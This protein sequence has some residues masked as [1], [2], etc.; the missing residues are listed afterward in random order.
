MKY[1][2]GISNGQKDTLLNFCVKSSQS[3][4]LI[5]L[6]IMVATLVLAPGISSAQADSTPEPG[7]PEYYLILAKNVL[8]TSISF[9]LKTPYCSTAEKAFD[10]DFL[11]G[12]LDRIDALRSEFSGKGPDLQMARK[13]TRDAH[14]ELKRKL[15]KAK[16]Q[17]VKDCNGNGSSSSSGSADPL[18]TG[19]NTTKPV[20]IPKPKITDAFGPDAPEKFC[21]ESE[22][23]DYIKLVESAIK[24]AKENVDKAR[25]YEDSLEGLKNGLE[26]QRRKNEAID[27]T[28]RHRKIAEK[29]EQTLKTI[30]EM[31]IEDCTESEKTQ[32]LVN[33]RLR[34]P[35]Q[36]SGTGLPLDFGTD[37]TESDGEPYYRVNPGGINR[38]G[39]MTKVP[40]PSDPSILDGEKP[41]DSGDTRSTYPGT[42]YGYPNDK[43]R[44][45][46][47]YRDYSQPDDG[48]E[49]EDTGVKPQRPSEQ[50]GGENIGAAPD[51]S[52]TPGTG[53][54]RYYSP[55]T[56]SGRQQDRAGSNA[57]F[58]SENT[59]ET[60][61]RVRPGDAELFQ[62]L[63]LYQDLPVPFII[64]DV[65]SGPVCSAAEKQA[66]IDAASKAVTLANHNVSE[67]GT[68][69]LSV[70]DAL[71]QDTSAERGGSDDDD[72]S[73]KC[74]EYRY[75]GDGDCEHS[76]NCEEEGYCGNCGGCQDDYTDPYEEL[77]YPEDP[78]PYDDDGYLPDETYDALDRRGERIQ[79]QL[80]HARQLQEQAKD[81][82]ERAK[83]LEVV[84]CDANGN[85]IALSGGQ[86]MGD[87][88]GTKKG[89][90]RTPG[91][92]TDKGTK[93]GRGDRNSGSRGATTP[94]YKPYS[95]VSLPEYYCSNDERDAAI[96]R[97]KQA[98][99]A[100]KQ[101]A[102]TA[103]ERYDYLVYGAGAE[104]SGAD[105]A[106]QA[107]KADIRKWESA[108]YEAKANVR[109]ADNIEVIE[110]DPNGKPL[111]KSGIPGLQPHGGYSDQYSDELDDARVEEQEYAP[112]E[113]ETSPTENT[114]PG[115]SS[116]RTGYTISAG[117]TIYNSDG[118]PVTAGSETDSEKKKKEVE[119]S[120][121]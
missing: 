93:M 69:M 103:N 112:I 58:D 8:T 12:Q 78:G 82:L 46:A 114:D 28:T 95:A 77:D 107:A 38:G 66:H 51:N 16:K 105:E 87:G 34:F 61:G 49:Q 32:R 76:G 110:C 4:R 33:L 3:H 47:K 2:T 104:D 90:S 45:R 59:S 52:R 70:R 25:R 50:S 96:R 94:R 73:L 10:V 5:L 115:Q 85:P 35:G 36:L 106:A 67:L 40:P 86:S 101:N 17:P 71:G 23:Y 30:K 41:E 1:T 109:A 26:K 54:S 118:S 100:A 75:Y 56:D 74:E 48:S 18:V 20:W 91:T 113:E 44:L 42:E 15:S 22:K 68:A 7:T 55:R 60:I 9:S 88:T 72:D 98:E 24:R 27:Q 6:L 37:D 29:L 64:P 31:D 43:L 80:R 57:G 121:E 39:G 11:Q 92:N 108:E 63:D 111:P 13:Y 81:N 119:K 117:P 116:S 53:Y 89:P 83:S 99:K 102:R 65:P 84:E 21:S 97:A 19:G 62:G 14:A 79:K 120:P